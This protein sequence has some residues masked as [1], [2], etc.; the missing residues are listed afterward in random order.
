MIEIKKKSVIPVYGVAVV[1]VLYCAFFPLYKT[2]HFVV[3]ACA[4]AL[5]YVFLSMVFPG[6]T[7]KIEVPAEPERTGDDKIDA[8]LSE[9][10]KAV[11]EMRG[12]RDSIGTASVKKKI[13]DIITVT[14]MIFQNLHHDPDDYT[15]VKRFADYYLPTTIKLLHTYSRFGQ[16]GAR[17]DNISGTMERID[18]AL[19]TIH[20]SYKKFFD[21]L[22]E[23]QAIDIETDISVLENVLRREG[24]LGKEF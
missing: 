16:S 13:D 23:N 10:G 3:L 19:D 4:A 15:Q 6:K 11:A 20:D 9:G 1:W 7:V 22:F 5:F 17:G 8:L 12:L 14:D 21:S 24:L 2:W 18:S